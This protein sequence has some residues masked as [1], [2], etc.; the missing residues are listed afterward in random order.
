[1]IILAILS[2]TAS[3]LMMIY[4]DLSIAQAG[5]CI[6]WLLGSLVAGGFLGAIRI[7]EINKHER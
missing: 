7:V 3:I 2:A 5:L 1:M 6:I 4:V